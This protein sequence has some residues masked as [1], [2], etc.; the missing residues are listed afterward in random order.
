M[1]NGDTGVEGVMTPLNH[2]RTKS[3]ETQPKGHLDTDTKSMPR[4]EASRVRVPSRFW[5]I[6]GLVLGVDEQHIS[7]AEW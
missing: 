4:T 1:G 6:D 2:P 5:G 3:L 7:Q